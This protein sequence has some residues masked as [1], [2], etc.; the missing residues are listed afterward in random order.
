MIYEILMYLLS[1]PNHYFTE[2]F[3]LDVLGLMLWLEELIYNIF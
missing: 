2:S 1:L 3:V